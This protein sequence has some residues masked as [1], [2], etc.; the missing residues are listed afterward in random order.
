MPDTI[1][2]RLNRL[3]ESEDKSGELLRLPPDTYSKMSSYSQALKR[4]AGSS[5][6]ELSNRL[7]ARQTSMIRSMTSQL[8]A[9]RLRKAG[10]QKSWHRLL[11]EER[12]VG[13]EQR[14]FEGRFKGLVEAVS[15]GQPSLVEYAR[16]QEAGRRMTVRFAK[17][18][19]EVVGL[20][21][22]RYGPFEPEDVASLPAGSADILVA[23][24]HAI[25][26]RTR[27]GDYE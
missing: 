11:P 9:L 20:D 7:I 16:S 25:E 18:V 1:I 19:E 22:K 24:G 10:M 15:A 23:S 6:S 26:V 13:S 3:L 5:A 14:R 4:S 17:R 8:I 12:Y 2:E 21:L 27:G